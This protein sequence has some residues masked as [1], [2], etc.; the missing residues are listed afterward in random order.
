MQMFSENVTAAEE[1]FSTFFLHYT[2]RLYHRHGE[3]VKLFRFM[4]SPYRSIL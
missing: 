2:G 1:I 4:L 3:A